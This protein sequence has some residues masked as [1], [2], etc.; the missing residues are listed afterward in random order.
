[1]DAVI[2][3]AK[4]DGKKLL[5]APYFCPE[6]RCALIF[7]KSQNL[8]ELSF[9]GIILVE[10]KSCLHA[11]QENIAEY[12]LME[13]TE[14]N[15]KITRKKANAIDKEIVKEFKEHFRKLW[16]KFLYLEQQYADFGE[17][18]NMEGAH[19]NHVFFIVNGPYTIKFCHLVERK[20]Y[21]LI[22]DLNMPKGPL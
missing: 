2:K 20:F 11:K 13:R 16:V 19:V 12:Y 21:E 6:N 1:L 22:A 4:E 7:P 18:I 15:P 17:A 9:F 10:T 14:I 5:Q 3:L 8:A